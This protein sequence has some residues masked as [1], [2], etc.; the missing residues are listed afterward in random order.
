MYILPLQ[1]P[2]TL[3]EAGGKACSLSLMARH[4]FPVPAGFVIENGAFEHFTATGSTD[5]HWL[6]A[7]LEHHLS[8]VGAAA[9]MVRSSGVGEDSEQGSFA[10]QLQSFC[11]SADTQNILQH[12]VKCWQSYHSDNVQVYQQHAGVQLQGMGVVVQQL[13]E[14]DYAG[15][16]FTQAPGGE[17]VMLCEYVQG[18]GEKLVSGQENPERFSCSRAVGK[19]SFAVPF[20]FEAL[21]GQALQLEQ[22][23][24]QPL[25]IE[26]VA[27]D[28]QIWL[29]QARPITAPATQQQV[30]WSNT[31]VNENYPT[32][33]S[34]L[35]YS[36]ARDAYYH[37]FKNL[38]RLLQVPDAAVKQLEP[39]YSNIIGIFGCKMYYNMS[40]IH[41]II[42]FSPFAKLLQQSFDNF[43]GYQDDNKG[44]RQK[45]SLGSSLRFL[46]SF[47]GLLRQLEK[48][49]RLFEQE[50]DAYHTQTRTAT[51]PAQLRDLFHGFLQI[52]MHSWY[53][54]SLADFFAMIF[55]GLLGRFCQR[56]FPEKHQGIQNTLLQA[57][58]DLVSS[59]PVTET[60]KIV[61]LLRQ[62]PEALELL[63]TCSPAQ[64]LAVLQQDD[65]LRPI[66]TAIDTYLH[67]WGFRCSGELMLTETNFSEEPKKFIQLLKSYLDQAHTSPIELIELKN[68]ERLKLLKK[69]KKQLVKRRGLLF[70]LGLAEA[71]LFEKLV[72]LCTKGIAARERVRLKQALLYARF[73]TVL[74]KIGKNFQ[75]KGWLA[76]EQDIFFLKYQEIAE[77]LTVSDMLPQQLQT[78]VQ[79]RKAQFEQNRQLVYPDDFSS[80]A[81]TYPTPEQVQPARKVTAADGSGIKGLSACG[82]YVRGR[83]RVLESIM[84]LHKIQQGDILVTRQTDPGWASIFPLISGLVVERGGMLS[85]GA[86]VAR[87][88]GIPAIVGVPDAT[89][90][91]TDGEEIELDADKGEIY[92]HAAVAT[93]V[94][95][96]AV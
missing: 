56:Y 41:R 42:G 60:W 63:Q 49:V 16:L 89:T 7:E 72:K 44:G 50:A 69:L 45:S 92:Q 35:L 8:Q 71:A 17:P 91:I 66:Q 62:N 80:R 46:R 30:H 84:E 58:P 29:V 4:G 38:S 54:A 79:A 20:P 40:S 61:Q 93:P 76:H 36:I 10:G 6:E 13:I 15:V 43:V 82:G 65:K 95:E 73:K 23:Y 31:N 87:E 64:F 70:P 96:A 74:L 48:N 3:Q 14:P 83:A 39:D 37:Y 52:R 34:P 11:C 78:I 86:I 5:L 33:I 67:H 85:H 21:Y 24:Q 25:D 94:Y 55:H 53:K 75:R 32:A 12:I 28:G 22:L 68:R 1:H 27:K 77:N 57:I 90:R 18:H 59:K 51:S 26:W 2:L 81:G 9:Y 88:F 19:I 47:T